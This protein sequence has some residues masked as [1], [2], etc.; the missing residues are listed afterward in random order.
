MLDTDST[1]GERTERTIDANMHPKD[2]MS[3]E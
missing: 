2:H 3:S 1:A